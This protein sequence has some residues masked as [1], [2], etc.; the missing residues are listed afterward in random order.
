MAIFET[1]FGFLTGSAAAAAGAGINAHNRKKRW[2]EYQAS[3]DAKLQAKVQY[4]DAVRA[5]EDAETAKDRQRLERLMGHTIEQDLAIKRYYNLPR[6]FEL[7]CNELD[8]SFEAFKAQHPPGSPVRIADIQY[9]CS[10]NQIINASEFTYYPV[11][12]E[13]YLPLNP[14]VYEKMVKRAFWRRPITSYD[15]PDMVGDSRIV[16]KYYVAPGTYALGKAREQ[17]IREGYLPSNCRDHLWVNWNPYIRWTGSHWNEEF[18]SNMDI[19]YRFELHWTIPDIIPD[20]HFAQ[21]QLYER[22]QCYEMQHP[23]HFK[24]GGTT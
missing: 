1:L 5:A 21:Y 8:K 17:L 6:E 23:E 14:D 13:E 11:Y 16:R 15:G 12:N 20:P 24:Q 10:W 18:H 4:G 19:G 9:K 3:E 7:A 2:N 22:Q